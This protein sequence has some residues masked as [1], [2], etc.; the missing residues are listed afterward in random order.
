MRHTLNYP[1]EEKNT[2]LWGKK[3]QIGDF[4]SPVL[5]ALEVIQ[6]SPE[7]IYETTSQSEYFKVSLK[8]RVLAQAKVEG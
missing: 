6:G 1:N 2:A 7:N 4:C 3:E 5:I 8:I